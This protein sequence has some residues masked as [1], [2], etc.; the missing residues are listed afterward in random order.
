VLSVGVER[1][2]RLQ[3]LL[4]LLALE[5]GSL[6]PTLQLPVTDSASATVSTAV[7]ATGQTARETEVGTTEKRPVRDRG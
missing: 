4:A 7:S 1:Q 3:L 2:V 5:T 6:C